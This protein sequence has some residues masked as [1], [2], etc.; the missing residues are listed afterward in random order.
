MDVI[1]TSRWTRIKLPTPAPGLSPTNLE[2]CLSWCSEHIGQQ[3]SDISIGHGWY[4]HGGGIFV[5]LEQKHAMWFTL[6]WS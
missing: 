3:T 5:F 2:R 6:R 1:N 4:Y